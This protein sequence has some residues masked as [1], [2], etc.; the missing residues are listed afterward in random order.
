MHLQYEEIKFLSYEVSRLYYIVL[1]AISK[2]LYN[3]QN[4]LRFTGKF[5]YST[6]DNLILIQRT[7]LMSI[8]VSFSLAVPML[9]FVG[10]YRVLTVHRLFCIVVLCSE[11]HVHRWLLVSVLQSQCKMFLLNLF[12]ANYR[13]SELACPPAV[14]MSLRGRSLLCGR[15]VFGFLSIRNCGYVLLS[16][17]PPEH[18]RCNNAL[19]RCFEQDTHT[20]L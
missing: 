11:R 14:I 1:R 16:I 6:V 19:R 3:I 17:R 4:V 2:P 10:R 18:L 5:H 7:V 20:L 13:S 15:L 12:Q 9:L 8:S